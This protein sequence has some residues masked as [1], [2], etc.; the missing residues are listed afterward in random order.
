M[1]ILTN[2]TEPVTQVAVHIPRLPPELWLL[3][4]R[5]ATSAPIT[6]ST[7]NY[8]PFRPRHETATVHSNA[9]LR[10]KCAIALVCRQWGALFGDMIYE[11]IRIGRVSQRCM[12]P[13]ARLRPAH[14]RVLSQHATA[15]AA[16]SCLMHILQRRRT[17]PH[18]P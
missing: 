15:Y 3:I 9:A 8:E 17:T 1:S 12:P 2:S 16:P 11:D 6:E 18:Q 5:F 4:F 10:D 13:S 14:L 7:H